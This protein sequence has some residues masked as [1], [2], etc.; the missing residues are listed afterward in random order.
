[1]N[2]QRIVLATAANLPP[3]IAGSG[4]LAKHGNSKVVQDAICHFEG[5]RYHVLAWSIL[6]NHVHVVLAPIGDHTLSRILH[7][8]KSFTAKV[9]NRASGRT[10]AV[11]QRESFCR[12][13]RTEDE[14]SRAIRYV[15]Q[16]PVEA[17]LAATAETFPWS[18]AGAGFQ[19][20]K[21]Y[22]FM[23]IMDG[24][25][26]QLRQRGFLPTLEKPGMTQFV[27]W[28]LADAVVPSRI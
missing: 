6:P 24:R 12:A 17:G 19:R 25:W 26:V 1:M 15:E 10:G 11:W 8:W 20:S 14:L 21:D 13:I 2:T 5:D 7:S 22:R 3:I 18:S 27:T 4:L 9:I 16:N 23:P 28:R